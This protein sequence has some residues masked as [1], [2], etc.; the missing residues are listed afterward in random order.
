MNDPSNPLGWPVWRRGALL[1]LLWLALFVMVTVAVY[2]VMGLIG[3]SGT[4][5]VL[6]AMG[7]GPVLGTVII[8]VWWVIRRPTLASPGP[9]QPD[10]ER[11]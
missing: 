5:R 11:D 2:G 10:G 8:G 4:A 6:C 1:G 9:H 7:T 3:W